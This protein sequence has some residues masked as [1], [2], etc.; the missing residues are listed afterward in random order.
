[1]KKSMILVIIIAFILCSLELFDINVNA[2]TL[3]NTDDYY[4]T[5]FGVGFK[6]LKAFSDKRQLVYNAI[7]GSDSSAEKYLSDYDFIYIPSDKGNDT[8][9]ITDILITPR[10]CKVTF[11]D[12]SFVCYYYA[13]DNKSESHEY[14]NFAVPNGKKETVNRI[15][16]YLYE[17]PYEGGYYC[18]NNGRY[19]CFSSD[20]DLK[21]CDGEP[22]TRVFLDKHFSESEGKL[23]YIN[24]TGKKES[25][26]K[27]I[28]DHKYF[29][30][31]S[32]K[33]AICGKVAKI[34]SYYYRFNAN[35]ICTGKYTGNIKVNGKKVY[36]KNGVII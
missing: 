15:D 1:M 19:F 21:S 6:S 22:L 20:V 8:G 7:K 9:D 12:C 25:G 24:D 28:G 35:G 18:C 29:F 10:Y 30:R 17:H 34:G 14:T 4:V 27:K 13:D 36:C 32:S 23:Y 3:D 5:E 33:T 2:E 11:K 16:Y 26:W 31:S